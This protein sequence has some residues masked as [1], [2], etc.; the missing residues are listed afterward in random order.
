MYKKILLAVDQSDHS[1]KAV[2][3][4]KD[5]AEKLGADVVIF[6]SYELPSALTDYAIMYHIPEDKQKQMQENLNNKHSK[7]LQSI[8]DEFNELEVNASTMY[9][10]ERP[11]PAIVETAKNLQCDLIVM[12]SRGL[13]GVQSMF[14]GSVSNYVLHNAEIPLLIV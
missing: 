13:S 8:K 10:N 9:K 2:N 6:H 14:V 1:K 11:G 3:H 4:T 5:L 7:F 12:G